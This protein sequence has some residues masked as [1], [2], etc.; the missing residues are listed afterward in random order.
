[1]TSHSSLMTGPPTGK[2]MNRSNENGNCSSDDVDR[3]MQTVQVVVH[4]PTLLLGLVLNLLAIRGFR[5]FL[6]KR[7]PKYVATCIHMINLAVFDL[8]MVLS[9]LFK[10]V[11]VYVEPPFASVCTLVECLYFISMYGGIFT[12]CFI[13]LDRY[14]AL[15]YPF[16]VSHRRSPRKIFGVCCAI[17]VLV[18]AGSIPFYSSSWGK[19]GRRCFNNLSDEVWSANIF[20]PVEV[21]GFFLPLSIMGFC[22]FKSIHILVSRQ[23]TTPA[24]GRKRRACIWTIAS[25]LAVFVVSFLPV[26]IAFFLQFLVRNNFIWE[27]RV[28]QNITLFVKLSMCLSNINCCLDVFCYYFAIKELHMGLR[29][30]QNSRDRVELDLLQARTTVAAE[31]KPSAEK[32]DGSP[33]S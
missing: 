29:D 26:H 17:W 30:K 13:S 22:S 19:H 20:F 28:K 6:R 2:N 16:L 31:R 18:W 8:L 11:L 4:I 23:N 27:C 12:I 10:I 14:L 25:N 21:F 32:G 5:A 15:Q 1:M 3:L 24:L 33:G 7:L 9:L